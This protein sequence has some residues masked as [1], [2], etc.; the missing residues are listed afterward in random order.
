VQLD[1]YNIAGQKVRTL[2]ADTVMPGTHS[3]VWNGRD[4]YGKAV[5]SG[6]YFSRITLSGQSATKRMLLMK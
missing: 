5:S 2:L 6:V 4:D 3:L 1:I